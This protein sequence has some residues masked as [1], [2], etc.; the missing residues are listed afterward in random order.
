M[1]ATAIVAYKMN[2]LCINSDNLYATAQG[3]Q[4]RLT[5][6]LVTY[7]SYILKA[8]RIKMYVTADL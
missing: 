3:W 5:H 1:Y 7:N 8:E 6:G 2:Q 4:T